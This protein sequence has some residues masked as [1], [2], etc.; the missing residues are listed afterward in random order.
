M[1]GPMHRRKFLRNAVATGVAL[2]ASRPIAA[3][4]GRSGS[5]SEK[6]IVA[7]VGT[8]GRGTAL[9][10]GFSGLGGAEVA[11]VCD[12]DEQAAEKARSAAA[13]EQQRAPKVV[14]DFRRALDDRSLDAV[15]VA[16]PNHWHGPATILACAAGK[17]VYVEKPCC[18]NPREGELMAEAARKHGRVVQVGTQR[19]SWEVVTEAMERLHKGVIGRAY[20]ATG[21]YYN[22]RGATGRA[23]PAG[24]P[25]GLNYDLWQGPA[26]RRD[27][28][29]N[30]VHYKWHWFWHWGNGELGNNG[31]HS[32][33]LCRWGLEVNAPIRVASGGGRYHF[34]DDQETPDTHVA[35]FDFEGGK[36]IKWEGLSCNSH[37]PGDTGIAAFHG[38]KGSLVLSDSGYTIY[39]SADKESEKVSGRGDDSRHFLDFTGCIR[40]GGRARCD[41]ADAHWSTLLCHLGNIAYRAGRT[42]HCD[43]KDGRIRDDKEAMALWSR[44]YEKGW[45]PTV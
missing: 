13:G 41:I 34:Q 22:R 12:V 28:C 35:M 6:V 33:D 45:E 1:N 39:D 3:S 16:T 5:A 40:G 9:A 36:A 24:V 27:Y 25:R 38:D 26:P 7:V 17:H 18:H 44:E 23:T 21:W 4:I 19:R 2:G 31:V 43:P 15:V 8:N 32:L 42:L 10:R 20:Y 37:G 29:E 11:Y 14:E 30:R